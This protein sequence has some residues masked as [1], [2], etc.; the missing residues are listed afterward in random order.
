MLCKQYA[1]TITRVDEALWLRRNMKWTYELLSILP[2]FIFFSKQTSE[3]FI[4][5]IGSPQLL[6]SYCNIFLL[7]LNHIQNSFTSGFVLYPLTEMLCPQIPHGSFPP[8]I[9]VSTQN[10]TLS[11]RTSLIS[12]NKITNPFS[13]PSLSLC[14]IIFLQYLSPHGV[15][16]SYLLICLVSSPPT[17]T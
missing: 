5:C 4:V 3:S 9:Q 14:C 17:M 11:V 10:V 2:I 16:Y 1:S 12:L 13:M 8:F 7:L 6:S 15:L